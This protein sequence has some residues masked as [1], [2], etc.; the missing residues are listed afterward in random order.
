[1]ADKIQIDASKL[2]A[3]M[4]AEKLVELIKS[5][6]ARSATGEKQR[7]VRSY[8]VGKLTEKYATEYET[9]RKEAVALFEAK[10]L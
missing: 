8:A 9:Y 2:P 3:G 4:T 1:M 7:K 6:E 10:K 5:Y